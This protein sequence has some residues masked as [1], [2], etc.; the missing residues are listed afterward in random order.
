MQQETTSTATTNTS[1]FTIDTSVPSISAITTDAFSWGAVLNA[2]EDNSDGTVDITTVG[3]EDGRPLTIT[4]NG[5]TYT[6]N[7]LSNATTVTIS[8]AG[9]QGLTNGQSYTIIANVSDAAGN[10][11][12]PVTSSSFAVDTSVP[13]ISAIATSAFSWGAVLNT[14]EDNSNGTVTVTTV[15]VEDGRPLTITLNGNTY[16]ATV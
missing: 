7:I 3:V 16:T 4:L 2:I 11:A 9:L 14:T 6:S 15:G 5:I 12:T 1:S 13:S 10:A 8:A